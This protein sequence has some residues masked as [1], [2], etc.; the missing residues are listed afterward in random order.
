[1]YDVQ[2]NAHTQI[3]IPGLEHYMFST[4]L[5]YFSYF[6]ISLNGF[7]SWATV[8]EKYR[9]Q[10]PAFFLKVRDTGLEPVTPTMSM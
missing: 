8:H 3:I 5:G 1:M 2:Y 7:K 9:A 6:K 10:D 4:R